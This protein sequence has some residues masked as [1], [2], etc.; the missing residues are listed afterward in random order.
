MLYAFVQVTGGPRPPMPTG[1]QPQFTGMRPPAPAAYTAQHT[2][3]GLISSGPPSAQGGFS[4]AG[5][6]PP[7]AGYT[8]QGLAST[9]VGS[10]PPSAGYTGQGFGA[11]GAG[12]SGQGLVPPVAGQTGQGLGAITAGPTGGIAGLP[13]F[14]LV[15]AADMRRYQATFMQTDTDRDGLVKVSKLVVGIKTA[16]LLFATHLAQSNDNTITCRAQ[17]YPISMICKAHGSENPT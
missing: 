3:A 2:G 14:P 16:V 5:S 12:A 1:Y 6:G 10:G 13:G 8:G 9:A 11:A 15:T 17:S 4:T 7:S